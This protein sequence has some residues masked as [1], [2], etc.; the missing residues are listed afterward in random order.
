MWNFQKRG[1]EKISNVCVRARQSRKTHHLQSKNG[2]RYRA[3]I[4]V[5]EKLLLLFHFHK[6]KEGVL[7]HPSQKWDSESILYA[8]WWDLKKSTIQ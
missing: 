5:L 1:L 2:L 8:F 7:L 3:E 6:F 4:S